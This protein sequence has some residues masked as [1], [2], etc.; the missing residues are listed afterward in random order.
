IFRRRCTTEIAPHDCGR[1]RRIVRCKCLPDCHHS[2]GDCAMR[3]IISRFCVP[4]I[5]LAALATSARATDAATE[6]ERQLLVR[7]AIELE[8]LKS[9]ADKAQSA[10]DPA[11]RIQFDYDTLIS[12]LS[13]IQG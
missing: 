2:N 7:I 9:L 12:D 6:V 10:S 11:R 4:I 1:A 8:Y 13:E 3:P 5:M